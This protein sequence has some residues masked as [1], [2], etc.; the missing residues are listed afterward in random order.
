MIKKFWHVGLTVKNLNE[1]IK[2]YKNLGFELVDEFEKPEP[3]AYAAEMKHANGS[4]IEI[5]QWLD[6]S[7][8]QVEFIKSHMAFVSD[9]QDADVQM[10]VDQGWEIVIPKTTGVK[11]TYVFLRDPS[12]NYVEVADIKE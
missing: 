11:V 5:W 6:E 1:A 7:H 12:G 2:Y 8:P 3:H 9:D 10:L 4:G